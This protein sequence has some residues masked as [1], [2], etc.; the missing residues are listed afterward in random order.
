[1]RGRGLNMLKSKRMLKGLGLC[2]AWVIAFWQGLSE[3]EAIDTQC[4][5]NCTCQFDV[6]P[7]ES[8]SWKW[9]VAKLVITLSVGLL[10]GT[11]NILAR[12]WKRVGR[13]TEALLYRCQG[14]NLDPIEAPKLAL[15]AQT[16]LIELRRRREQRG[17]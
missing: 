15:Q 4:H 2:A 13:L 17:Y 9:E 16:Q 10:V 8:Y 1:M 6:S 12:L 14:A 11:F 3:K 7:R 5:C